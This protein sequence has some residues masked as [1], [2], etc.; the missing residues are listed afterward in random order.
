MPLPRCRPSGSQ[1]APPTHRALSSHRRRRLMATYAS[2]ASAGTLCAAQLTLRT[3]ARR[4][5]AVPQTS[6]S[7]RSSTV[8]CRAGA[9]VVWVKEDLRLHDNAALAAAVAAASK[10]SSSLAVVYCVDP[11]LPPAVEVGTDGLQCSPPDQTHFDLR[12]LSGII[13]CGEHYPSVHTRKAR[14]RRSL[15]FAKASERGARSSSF[16]ERARLSRRY[17]R[18]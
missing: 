15:R 4:A 1:P 14:P 17:R 3:S 8:K 10:E 5:R 13:G 12:F 7:A 18:W 2:A 16:C 11:S 9:E 6:L